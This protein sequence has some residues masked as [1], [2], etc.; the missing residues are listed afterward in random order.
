[1]GHPDS[2]TDE[3]VK[4]KGP[5]CYRSWFSFRIKQGGAQPLA[6]PERAQ[7]SDTDAGKLFLLNAHRN[8]RESEGQS[9]LGT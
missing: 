4:A 7:F 5:T 3:S 6:T 2:F 8:L 9:N 1:M